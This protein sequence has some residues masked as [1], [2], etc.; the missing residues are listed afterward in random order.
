[1]DRHQTIQLHCL[2]Q[3]KFQGNVIGLYYLFYAS[4][5]ENRNKFISFS[6]QSS[7]TYLY[8]NDTKAAVLD[9]F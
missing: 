6:S 7:D 8:A 3:T 1:M 4:I 2:F 5:I 9:S